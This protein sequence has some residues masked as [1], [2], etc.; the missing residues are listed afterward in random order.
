MISRDN[1][2]FSPEVRRLVSIEL[3]KARQ[4]LELFAEVN[5]PATQVS[6]IR[7]AVGVQETVAYVSGKAQNKEPW[8]AKA[9]VV[10][11]KLAPISQGAQTRFTAAVALT[12][13]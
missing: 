2:R 3:P 1:A 7:S 12:V 13:M 4:D 9:L 8:Q 10:F 5:V 6:H 11:E